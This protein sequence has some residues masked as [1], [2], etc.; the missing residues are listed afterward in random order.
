M[1]SRVKTILVAMLALCALSMNAETNLRTPKNEFRSTWISTVWGIDWPTNV[2]Y[3]SAHATR[4]KQQMTKILDSLAVNNFNAVCFQV[5]GMSDA[6]YKSPYEPWSEF[7]TG[8]RGKEPTWDPLA[9]VVEEC[10]KR[11]MECH[12]WVNPY[13][14][15]TS[16]SK[17]GAGDVTGYYEKG[18]LI[19]NPSGYSI[20]NPSKEEVQDHIVKICKEIT[21]NYDIDG[22]LFDD[23]YYNNAAL[24]KD[25]ADYDAY[26]AAGGTLGQEDWRRA[27]V[28]N[29]MAKLYKMFQETK[30]WIRFGQAPPGGTFTTK[31]LADKYGID[32]CPSGSENCYNSQYIDIMGWLK[33]G[34]IDY[35]SP[36]VYWAI[37]FNTADYG[38]MV[39]WWG[40]VA[41]KFGR[42]LF[43]SQD[44]SYVS[45]QEGAGM[46]TL[47]KEIK[48]EPMMLT[49]GSCTT[50]G[51]VE[52][53]VALN[54]TSS[55][56]GAFGSIYF[57][58]KSLYATGEDMPYTLGHNL[59]RSLYSMRALPPA[60]TWK[61]T[62]NPGKVSNL[63]YNGTTLSW[64]AMADAKNKR[65]TVYAIPNGLDKANFAKDLKYMLGFTYGNAYELPEEYRLGYYYAV[66]VY[67]RFGNEWD[68]A[69]YQSTA[70]SSLGAPTIASPANNA[71]YDKTFDF[72][73][74][75]V[76]GAAKYAIEVATESSFA[77]IVAV[78]QTAK[79][80]LSSDLVYDKIEKNKA[81]YWRVRALASDKKD[82]VS[83]TRVF[84][85]AMPEL[86]SP[87]NG[88]TALDPKVKFTWNVTT[89][90]AAVKIEVASDS[91]FTDIVLSTESKTGGYQ[92]PMCTLKQQ[93]TYY[94][95]LSYN[96]HY[97]K[98]VAFT[99]KHIAGT[100][101]SFKFPLN[102]GTLWANN[103]VEINP[104]EG[105]EEV[106][107][108]IDSTTSF[109]GT[110][111]CRKVL[112][113]LVFNIP[114]ADILMGTKKTAMVDGTTY[115]AKARVKYYDET[116]KMATTDYCDVISFV[117]SSKSSAID[118]VAVGAEVKLAGGNVV[119]NAEKETSIKVSAV[120][121]L[122]S[123]VQL[124]EGQASSEEVSLSEL[125]SGMYIIKVVLDNEVRTLK[126]V[127]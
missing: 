55:L 111:R 119:I 95:R 44:I 39:P 88:A 78:A 33:A 35:I 70:T 42:H 112:T 6:M 23:Y 20:L 85:Y 50:F 87:A 97:S 61:T 82:G 25:K 48:R 99:T 62:S 54:R 92:T 113:D 125:S 96:G 66:C 56:N 81:L 15:N 45:S 58:S 120:S 19:K 21:Q 41:N 17:T 31:A 38:K 60:M 118:K 27:N 32:P 126:Y 14:F 123:E 106:E 90:G 114:A 101:P 22:M 68:A 64:T 53:Q 51:E 72:K 93:K 98:I 3:T 84:T 57:S 34:I 46:V 86:T 43:V 47:S 74:N 73:W 116:G 26:K 77:N 89:S 40:T 117:Y 52:D 63:A 59:K 71:K 5:R 36:Q 11:G 16:S 49:S 94:A 67:D 103:S 24:D 69:I 13:R 75:A 65:Y 1:R 80:S 105:A 12:A 37:G 18:W 8:T 9:F 104:Q 127:K 28:H 121:M 110:T 108:L 79:T 91:K 29:L 2:G 10:H 30:P 124:Y 107:V 83:E 4:Q 115:Y 100:V 109:G 102:G 76:S 122:G 7:L